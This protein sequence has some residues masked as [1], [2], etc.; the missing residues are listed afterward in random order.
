MGWAASAPTPEYKFVDIKS[1]RKVFEQTITQHGKEGWEFCGSERF[2]QGELVL[3]FK[4]AKGGSFPFGG[5]NPPNMIGGGWRDI[6][7]RVGAAVGDHDVLTIKLKNANAN[8]VAA[9]V[10]KVV[11]KGVTVVAEP[12]SNTVLVVGTGAVLKDIAKLI[13]DADAKPGKRPSGPMGSGLGGQGVGPGPGGFGP[14][15]VGPT[16][17]SGPMGPMP[18][19]LMGGAP[20][21]VGGLSV[22]SLKHATADELAPL[23]KKVFPTAEITADAR[24]NQLVVRAE[25]KTLEELQALLMRLDVEV[26]KKR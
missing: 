6:A 15:V 20:Q 9:L 24:T 16:L 7:G 19:G 17:G 8:D 11:P 3:V 14:G 22:L 4:K 2:G 21:P 23:L 26:P 1:D 18:G 13:E 12:V 5:Q 10:N 25:G